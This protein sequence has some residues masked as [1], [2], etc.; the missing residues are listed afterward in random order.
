MRFHFK[1][2]DR[3]AVSWL[4]LSCLVFLV[5]PVKVYSINRG[6]FITSLGV[7][8]GFFGLAALTITVAL[9]AASLLLGE[10]TKRLLTCLPLICSVFFLAQLE[11]FYPDYGSVG[12]GELDFSGIGTE[13]ARD[14]VILAALGI[15][16]IAAGRVVFDNAHFISFA[17]LVISLVVGVSYFS[18]SRA[19]HQ[20]ARTTTDRSIG[21][22]YDKY[23]DLVT[24]SSTFNIIH[25]VPDSLQTEIVLEI[26]EREPSLQEEFTG[27]TLF[28]NHAG[29]SLRTNTTFPV[30]LTGRSFFDDGIDRDEIYGDVDDR[31]YET[32]LFGVLRESGF[33]TKF[34]SQSIEILEPLAKDCDLLI[35]DYYFY[36]QFRDENEERMFLADLALFS[37][38]PSFARPL[39]YDDGEWLLLGVGGQDDVDPYARRARAAAVFFENVAFDLH[40]GEE[41]PVYLLFHAWPPHYPY[42]LGEHCEWRYEQRLEQGYGGY[43]NGA[44]CAVRIIAALLRRLKEL[45]LYDESLIIV[46][47]DTG[48]GYLGGEAVGA[49]PEV[50]SDLE[51]AW[52]DLLGKARPALLVKPPGATEPL[53]FSAAPVSIKNTAATIL[54]IAGLRHMLRTLGDGIVADGFFDVSDDSGQPRRFFANTQSTALELPIGK[55]YEFSISGHVGE[56]GSWRLIGSTGHD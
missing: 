40:V 49:I 7:M 18:S 48:V 51:L 38:V 27:F 35:F 46:Q 12:A 54:K 33:R 43:R 25:I 44:F 39:V 6:E 53:A 50:P 45:G 8:M 52:G 14:L 29:Y 36:K 24:L 23:V 56:T 30:M 41:D 21:Y 42:I 37:I 15:T 3:V 2:V 55:A 16:G 47:G 9:V 26:F 34:Y 5:A 20:Q 4:A 17:I 22:S 31:I 19:G 13:I 32:N 11:F 1:H 28:E 10:R